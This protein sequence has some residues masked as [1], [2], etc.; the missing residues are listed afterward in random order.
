MS[1]PAPECRSL[2]K[3]P[4][5]RTRYL[6]PTS[7]G[8]QDQSTWSFFGETMSSL[9]F[10]LGELV[11][12]CVWTE[13]HSLQCCIVDGA[14]RGPCLSSVFAFIH[15]VNES[16]RCLPVVLSALS[17]SCK[18]KL[19]LL[20]LCPFSCAFIHPVK[21]RCLPVV[22]SAV[23]SS[24]KTKSQLLNLCPFSCELIDPV[25]QSRSCLP[26]VLSAVSSSCKTKPAAVEPLSHQLCIHPSCKT[27]W[28]VFTSCAFSYKFIV[29]NKVAAV[30]PLSL[31]L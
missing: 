25:E 31:Q 1:T 4:M 5:W 6:A 26:V 10:L 20:N 28:L 8:K 14:F 15:P 17:S 23:S 30:E 21:D 24:C 29:L 18:T 3:E 22:L 16:R 11:R 12:V 27:K 19:Q 7:V 9:L 2:W 13:L